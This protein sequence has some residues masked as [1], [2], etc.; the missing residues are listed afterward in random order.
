[1]ANE[2]IK[3]DDVMTIPIMGM[4]AAGDMVPLPAGLTP[5]IVNSDPASL[6]AV[7]TGNSYTL[8]ALVP[9]ATGI[10]IEL[11]DGTLKPEVRLWDIVE[12][13][14]ATSVVSN[15]AQATHTSQPRPSAPP[16]ATP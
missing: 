14:E 10:S 15:L 3:N 12:D 5:T 8:R 2:Q 6:E 11:D 9:T 13:I 4:D 7:V 1:M 16:P